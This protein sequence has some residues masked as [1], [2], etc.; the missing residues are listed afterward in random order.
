MLIGQEQAK[1]L[2]LW[3]LFGV[4][5]WI[6]CMDKF[7]RRNRAQCPGIA[8]NESARFLI[9]DQTFSAD[10]PGFRSAPAR[11]WAERLRAKGVHHARCRLTARQPDEHAPPVPNP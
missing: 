1:R 11:T 5:A 2:V 8:R 4:P 3:L 10:V 6:A 9:P 7:G